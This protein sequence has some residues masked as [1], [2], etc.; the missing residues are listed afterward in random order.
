MARTRWPPPGITRMAALVAFSEE[1]KYGVSDGLWML[2]T[3][4][5]PLADFFTTSGAVFPSEPGAPSGHSGISLGISA[6][7]TA[8]GASHILTH[9]SRNQTA[10]LAEPQRRDERR[11]TQLDFDLCVR[12]VSA[13]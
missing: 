8:S 12:R 11:E 3:E 10:R 1:G 5:S 2:Q 7:K 13:V 6:A 4:I 9:R